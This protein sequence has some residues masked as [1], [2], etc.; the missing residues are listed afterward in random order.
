MSNHDHDSLIQRQFGGS[1]ERYRTSAS[2]ARGRSLA[3]LL[4]L[5][6]P[7]PAW[8][9]LDIATGTGH[10]AAMLAPQV[11]RVIAGDMTMEMLQQAAIVSREQALTNIHLVQESATALAHRDQVFDLVVCRIAAH[12]FPDP[13]RFVSE[14][15]RVLKATGRLAVI[16]NVVPDD[17]AVAEWINDFERQR[18][19]SH[20][21]CL[22]VTQWQKLFRCNGLDMLYNEV[23]EK[24]FD[25][26]E[27][28]QRMNVSSEAAERM[29]REL[30]DAPADVLDFWQP[31]RIDH[32]IELTLQEAILVGQPSA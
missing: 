9:V 28:M 26:H 14:A 7:Q 12:H 30:L 4:E 25:F 13:G 20:A 18:D 11:R 2:H 15:A 31:K 19:P 8:S 10:T 17:M 32:R 27:W 23:N 21:Q 3:R 6:A 16:D 22:S 24:W 5:T 1:A 29:G